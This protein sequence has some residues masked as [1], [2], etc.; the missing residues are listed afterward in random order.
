MLRILK[1]IWSDIQQGENIDLY[2]TVVI[3]ITLALLSIVGIAPQSLIEPITI[4][5]LALFAIS[6]MDD[7]DRAVQDLLDDS[8]AAQPAVDIFRV[9]GL[10][11]P[12]IAI[13][14]DEFLAG[15]RKQAKQDL[16]VRLLQKLLQDELDARQRQNVMQVRSFK[17]MLDE[18]ITRYNNH[19]IQAANVVQVM[20]EI[21]KQWAANEQ[22]KQQLNLNDEEL[23]F[24]DVIVMGE[25]M[26]ESTGETSN[27]TTD[28]EWIDSLV[29][30]VVKVVRNNLQVD[31]T[32]AH[33]QDVK[34]SVE[35]AVKLVLR[36]RRVKGEQLAFILNRLMKQAEAIYKDWPMAA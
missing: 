3:A 14:D 23:A 36:K 24:Y 2:V 34:A 20:V 7:L 32:Q 28:N 8:I 30:D 31:W 6:L 11:R 26:G 13:L 22:R 33:R 16:Q 18:A 12:D 9:T 27:I 4:T 17:Q 10:A 15:F 1:H 19:V 21:R 25:S 29:R 35:S 5:V